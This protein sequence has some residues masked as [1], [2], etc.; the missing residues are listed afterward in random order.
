MDRLAATWG[1]YTPGP[2][3]RDGTE[4]DE[5]DSSQTL[6]SS[7]EVEFADEGDAVLHGGGAGLL[8]SHSVNIKGEVVKSAQVRL[9]DVEG[10]PW[11]IVVGTVVMLNS[12]IIGYEVDHPE[13]W[14]HHAETFFALVFAVEMFLRINEQRW[15]FFTHPY[16][17]KWNL[18]DF[19]VVLVCFFDKTLFFFLRVN[20]AI[21]RVLRIL[22]ILRF[23]RMLRS[24][25]ELAIIAEGFFKATESVTWIGVIMFIFIYGCA[26]FTTVLIGQ[27]KPPAEDLQNLFGT[28]PISMLTLFEMVTLEGWVE[29]MTCVMDRRGWGWALFFCIF[30]MFTSYTC[31]ALLTAII[32]DQTMVAIHEDL[33]HKAQLEAARQRRQHAVVTEIFHELDQDKSGALSKEQLFHMLDDKHVE[34]LL[35]SMGWTVS[36]DE[37]SELF[38][39]LDLDG[40]GT[41]DLEE[42]ALGFGRLHGHARSRDLY[43][44]R[45]FLQMKLDR[46]EQQIQSLKVGSYGRGPHTSAPSGPGAEQ[47]EQALNAGSVSGG[48]PHCTGPLG[49]GAEQKGAGSGSRAWP[50]ASASAEQKEE[51]LQQA[52][53]AVVLLQGDNRRL[54]RLVA[55]ATAAMAED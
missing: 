38:H 21:L 5:E 8:R 7:G 54:K 53:R 15:A 49:A 51:A 44:V 13:P 33:E 6:R 2:L 18:F 12:L 36:R 39:L 52:L 27:S 1:G 41:I 16:D 26:I 35:I 22:R 4:S 31:L 46:L 25:R 29:I 14:C 55:D 28:L 30:V 11:M 43:S 20:P 50:H 32:T 40:S 3:R 47:Q 42:F 23:L 17:W 45:K 37:I 34:K 24:F 48:W 19:L 9:V 10:T